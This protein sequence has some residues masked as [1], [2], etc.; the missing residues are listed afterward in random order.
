MPQDCPN[1]AQQKEKEAIYFL[2]RYTGKL[3]RE[4]VMGEAWLKWIY[5]SPLGKLALHTLVKRAIFSKLLGATRNTASSKRDIA[6][7]VA[8][9]GIDMEE[10]LLGIDD[11]KH[12]NDFFYRKL[13]PTARPI[14]EG[15]NTLVFPSDARHMGWQDASNMQNVFVKGQQFDITA[16]LGSERLGKQYEHGSVVLSRLCPTDYHRFHFPADGTPGQAR[17]IPGPL[18]SVS[19]YC[20][21]NKISWLWTNKRSLTLLQTPHWGQIALLAVGATG[22]GGIHMTYRPDQP[23]HKGD[24]QGY[25]SFGGSTVMTFFEQ[26]RVQLAHDLTD[27]TSQC[28][29]LYARQGDVMASSSP[30]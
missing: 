23:V 27:L 2:N 30:S 5:G 8:S 6:P 12:F 21:K 14:A 19:P 11:F 4:Q 25:F 3:I 29:E 7:F 9:Y 26:G 13:K 1:N 24:E 20:L 22:V 16:L 28:I 17:L 15:A 18:A 10:S